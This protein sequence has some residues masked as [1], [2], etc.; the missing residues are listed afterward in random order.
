MASVLIYDRVL[1]DM[2][3]MRVLEAECRE[4]EGELALCKGGGGTEPDKEYNARMATIAERQQYLSDEYFEFWEE[5]NAVL[6][7]AKIKAE[8]GNLEQQDKITKQE[9][10]LQTGQL[11]QQ[12]AQLAQQG[13]I[14]Q[15]QLDLLQG[16]NQQAL[17]TLEQKNLIE[18]L[19]LGLTQKQ[20]ENALANIGQENR[21]YQGIL[22]MQ[23]NT[24]GTTG[25]LAQSYL[26]ESLDG[27]NGNEWANRAGVDQQIAASKANETLAR[28]ASRMGLSLNSGSFQSAMAD[29]ATKNAA[30]IG[31]ARTQAFRAA[32]KEKYNRLGQ[33]LSTGLGLLS[34]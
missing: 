9:L 5:N 17:D 25:E 30:N 32:D 15:Q 29:Q 27:V 12:L 16:Q 1:I 13:V 33:G 34:K 2:G 14:S 4:Y 10:Q 31:T 18:K 3:T 23:E 28:N 11:D 24:M 8:L 21:I 6:E 20:T 7:A 19:G 26:K 22:G